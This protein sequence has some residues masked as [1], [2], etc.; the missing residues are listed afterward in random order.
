MGIS[1][2]M[3]PDVICEWLAGR[4]KFKQRLKRRRFFNHRT[5]LE[6]YSV[7]NPV[8]FL[9]CGSL[10]IEPV[11]SESESLRTS[12]LNWTRLGQKIQ[13]DVICGVAGWAD[14]I[15]TRDCNELSGYPGR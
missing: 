8:R 14:R 9:G 1:R 7:R 12:G 15:R 5:P 6:R 11:T 3:Q 10:L 2:N 4:T 13:P